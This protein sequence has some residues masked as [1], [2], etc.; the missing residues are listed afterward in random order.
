VLSLAY[1]HGLIRLAKIS[2]RIEK[3]LSAVRC[4]K[5]G[6]ATTIQTIERLDAE[7]TGIGI[8]LK[9]SFGF[10]LGERVSRLSPLGSM[11]MDQYLYIQYA[12]ATAT[13]S[14]HTVLAYPWMRA[15]IGIRSPNQ[16]RDAITRSITAV[17]KCSREAILLTEH[18]QFTAGT[19]VP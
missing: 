1:C 3:K 10:V 2:S 6:P 17:T 7:L 8:S 12:Y 14:I 15:L 5:Q 18:I 9:E 4:V 19:T 11:T 16:H 13:L